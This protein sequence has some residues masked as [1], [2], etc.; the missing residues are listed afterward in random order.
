MLFKPVKFVVTWYSSNRK[1]IQAYGD[2]LQEG[3]SGDSEVSWRRGYLTWSY[4]MG[5][6]SGRER[7]SRADVEGEL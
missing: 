6:K 5:R 3:R 2:P 7:H 4:K 1:L